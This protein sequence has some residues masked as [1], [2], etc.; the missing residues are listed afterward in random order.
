MRL[1]LWEFIQ[2]NILKKEKCDD[3]NR[4]LSFFFKWCE[5]PGFG[6]KS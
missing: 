2:G 4:D 6:E 5:Q 3:K 1:M